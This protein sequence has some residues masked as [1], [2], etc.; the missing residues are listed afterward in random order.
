MTTT[1]RPEAPSDEEAIEQVTRRAFLSHPYSHQ[2]EQFIIRALRADHALSVSLVAEEAGRVVGHIALSPVSISDGAVGWYGLGPISVEPEW[3]GRGIGRALME[4]GLAELSRI[5]ANGCVLVG[6]PA[7]YTRFG[8]ANSPAL[9]L[10][11]VPPEF[12]LALSLDTAAAH[13]SVQFHPA[14]QA[15]R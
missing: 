4:R 13:G 14:F 12:F 2:T 11:G 7:F 1:I 9:V 8:F 10:E 3:Q 15:T 6:D 5:G